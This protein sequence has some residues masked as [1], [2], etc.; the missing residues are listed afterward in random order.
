MNSL[1]LILSKPRYFAPA[2]VFASL[3]ILLG[4]WVIYI[5]QVKARLGL[6]DGDLGVALFCYALGV[7]VMLPLIPLLTKKLGVG[8]ATLFGLI[9]FALAFI[10]PLVAETYPLLCGALLVTGAFS[11]GTDVA[12]NSLVSELEKTDGVSFMSAAHG[13]FSLG[14]VI[15][16]GIGGLIMH[17]FSLPVYH[18]LVVSC[19]V[20]LINA[21]LCRQYVSIAGEHESSI[22][23]SFSFAKMSPLFGLAFIAF[24]VMGSEGAIEHWSKLYMLEVVD[25]STE[26]LAGY[27]F[28]IFSAAMTTGRF[29]GDGISDRFGSYRIISCGILLATIGFGFILMASFAVTIFGFALVGLGLSVVIPELFRIAGQIQSV[30]AS[31]AISFVSGLGFVGFLLGPVVLGYISDSANLHV[32][33]TV[34]LGLSVIAVAFSLIISNK[35]KKVL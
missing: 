15:G 4:T 24:V 11:G 30:S 29:F 3:N 14:G 5:P 20:L 17:Y 22:K 19:I 35:H 6:D 31:L 7:M 33:F 12:M 18:M 8:R 23:E 27:G 25:V 9:C 21:Y 13:F 10:M 26:Q 32:S 34:L 16:A 1:K 2:F 28:V